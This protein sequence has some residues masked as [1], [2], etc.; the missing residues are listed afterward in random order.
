MTSRLKAGGHS[1]AEVF[2][3]DSRC[4]PGANVSADSGGTLAPGNRVFSRHAR[5]CSQVIPQ[6]LHPISLFNASSSLERAR[7]SMRDT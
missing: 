5:Y 4:S 2:W 3:T 6:I 7:F 1:F